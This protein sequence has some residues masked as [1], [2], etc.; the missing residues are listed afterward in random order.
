MAIVAR[1][2]Q[3]NS[4]PKA[5][6]KPKP[7]NSPLICACLRVERTR[8]TAR[9]WPKSPACCSAYCIHTLTDGAD[10][11]RAHSQHR[12][13][14]ARRRTW[15]TLAVI[16]PTESILFALAQALEQHDHQTAGHCE[17]LAL[18]GFAMGNGARS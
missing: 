15:G 6:R 13:H 7:M 10:G 18:I 1:A 2:T 9:S 5:S 17:R 3:L 16:D 8:S 11:A 4:N 12:V 14:T